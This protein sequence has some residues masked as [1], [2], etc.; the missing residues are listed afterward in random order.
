MPEV[1][2]QSVDGLPV[3]LRLPHDLDLLRRWGRVFAVLDQQDSGNLCFGVEGDAGRVF[4]KYAGAAPE[5]YDGEA[6]DA[7]DRARHAATVHRDLAHPAL[8]HLRETA[9]T[10]GG[11][12][13]VFDWVD[14][15]PLGQQYQRRGELAGVGVARRVAAVQDVYDFAEHAASRGWVAVDLYDG[16]LMMDP[17]S[18]HVTLCDL[19]LFARA[20]LRN[21]M[22]RMWGSERFMAPE[23]HELGA[24][25]DEVTNVVPLGAIAHTL[26]GDD[27]S[28]SRAA[29]IGSEAQFRV[30]ERALRSDRD[31]R[32][33]SVAALAAAW[34]RASA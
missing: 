5:R 13:L 7:V 30:A 4:V 26:L 12:A 19:D 17:T 8:V 32:W 24:V 18:G 23:E 11:V 2:T 6:A 28:K 14:A 33:P 25:L 27:R 22:G 31:D 15:V 16:S 29:W 21:T 1:I 9:E 20:P 34:R 10:A 3:R